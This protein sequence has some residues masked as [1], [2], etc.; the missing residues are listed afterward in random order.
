MFMTRLFALFLLVPA[1]ALAQ[2]EPEAESEPAPAA[3][4]ERL[5]VA[6]LEA[7]RQGDELGFAGRVELLEPVIAASFDFETIASIV[8]GRSWK[9][10]SAEQ[11]DAFLDVFRRLSVAT[12]ASNFSSHDGESF[13]TGDTQES[14]GTHIVRTHLEQQDGTQ[15]PL[16]YLLRKNDD[17]W[18]IVNVVAQGVS[19]LSLKRAE[20]TAII[21][22]EG[23]DSL[24]SRL[25]EKVDDMDG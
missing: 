7:M 20:Y 1:C 11:R 19:D 3:V 8:T 12:Y 17:G 18:K 2:A 23:F 13:V 25:H 15:I 6:L 14:R 16:N 9:T 4:V 22:D 10:A 21:Q 24:L 5:H